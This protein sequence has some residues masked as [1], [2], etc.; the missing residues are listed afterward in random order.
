MALKQMEGLYNKGILKKDTY[1]FSYSPKNEI[2]NY[3][4]EKLFFLYQE[5]PVAIV[6]F[7]FTKP[8]N[9]LK[10]FADAFK[11]KKD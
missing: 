1:L 4:L 8:E 2:I 6:T 9:K 10:G 7:I 3:K 5:R 11:I